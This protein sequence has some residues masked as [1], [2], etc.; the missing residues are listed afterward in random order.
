MLLKFDPNKKDNIIKDRIK[1]MLDKVKRTG[2]SQDREE[3]ATY[4]NPSTYKGFACIIVRIPKK[5][6][7]YRYKA[8]AKEIQ[9]NIIGGNVISLETPYA[10]NLHNAGKLLYHYIDLVRK[11]NAV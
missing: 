7:G 4:S 11:K 8:L 5:G 3:W 9:P 1:S 6:F 10:K 2:T